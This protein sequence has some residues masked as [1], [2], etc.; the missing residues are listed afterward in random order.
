M[1]FSHQT[2]N[3]LLPD[4]HASSQQLSVHARAAVRAAAAQVHGSN[5]CGELRVALRSGW[6]R[7]L[8]PGVEAAARHAEHAAHRADREAHVPRSD[9]GELHSLSFAKNVAARSMGQGNTL[10]NFSAGEKKPRVFLG[11]AFHREPVVVASKSGELLALSRIERVRWTVSG[12][13]LCPL[14]PPAQRALGQIQVVGDLRNAAVTNCAEPDRLGLELRRERSPLT[15]LLLCP[16]ST[17]G[18]FSRQ[19]GCPR[20]RGFS[21]RARPCLR[22][23]S[24][25]VRCSSDRVRVLE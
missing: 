11:R 1:P 5:R 16:W 2:L 10:S 8:L 13:N 20:K 24:D 19:S 6:S 12:I 15:S 9:E 25:R 21:L 17:P 4:A 3:V 22:C 14:H 7:A 18:A 23:S